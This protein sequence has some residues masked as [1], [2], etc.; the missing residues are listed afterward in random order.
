MLAFHDEADVLREAHEARFVFSEKGAGGMQI[1]GGDTFHLDIQKVRNEMKRLGLRSW[2]IRFA[3]EMELDSFFDRFGARLERHPGTGAYGRWLN[4]LGQWD[5]WDLGGRFDG[6]I[7]GDQQMAQGRGVAEVSSGP[8][9]GRT[10]LVNI[11]D[12]LADAL[13]QNPLPVLDVR[14]DRNIEVVATLL[15]DARE[16]RENAYPATVVLPPDSVEDSLRWLNGWPE[17]GPQKAFT[18]LG[19]AA[20]ARWREIVEAAYS[21]FEDHWAAAIAYHH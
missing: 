20:D 3:D 15:G 5:W 18:W 14:N 13:G 9:R 8:N 19:A 2:S 7:I 21:R 16:G 11:G 4:P 10:I 17:M 1:E 6:R 12:V